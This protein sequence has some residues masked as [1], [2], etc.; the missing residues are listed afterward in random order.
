MLIQL[1]QLHESVQIYIYKNKEIYKYI[2][3]SHLLLVQDIDA[4]LDVRKSVR[5]GQDG[6]ALVLLIQ[7]AVR[8][9]VQRERSTVHEGAQV[10]VLV[11]VGNPLLHLVRV[12][13]W[14]HVGDLEVGLKK[15]KKKIQSIDQ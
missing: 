7:V 5:R 10:V 13:V 11:K 15:K 3:T 1:Q 12:E 6:F 8:S 2:N 9:A 14:L 4:C